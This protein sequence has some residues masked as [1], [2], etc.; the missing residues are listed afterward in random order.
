[1]NII[2]VVVIEEN[3]EEIL[4]AA[5]NWGS[6]QRYLLSF[7][8][9]WLSPPLHAARRSTFNFTILFEKIDASLIY[10]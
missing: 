7:L 9:P 8:V 4:A 6:R 5:S 3:D 1:M 2:G 10:L